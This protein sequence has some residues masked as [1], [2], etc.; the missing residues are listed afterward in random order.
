[1]FELKEKERKIKRE[2][3]GGMRRLFSMVYIVGVKGGIV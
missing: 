1:M 2:L 3:M